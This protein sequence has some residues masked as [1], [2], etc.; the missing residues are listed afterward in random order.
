MLIKSDKAKDFYKGVVNSVLKG[1]RPAPPAEYP[2]AVY[3]FLRSRW[4]AELELAMAAFDLG[5]GA[6]TAR[7]H[8]AESAGFYLDLQDRTAKST[9]PEALRT[10][11]RIATT[12][13]ADAA[14]RFAKAYLQTPEGK[15][16]EPS[17]RG[18]KTPNADDPWW[19]LANALACYYAG[20]AKGLAD[21]VAE[22][23]TV[24]PPK[25]PKGTDAWWSAMVEL[26][27]QCLTAPSPDP[28][29][30]L[31]KVGELS[32]KVLGKEAQNLFY[33][34]WFG[35]IALA[36]AAVAAERGWKIPDEDPHPSMPLALLRLP[37][38]SVPK[39]A[40][41]DLPVIEPELAAAIER[42]AKG[43]MPKPEGAAKKT[44]A[45]KTVAKK[46]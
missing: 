27:T 45:K 37:H 39:R 6:E 3:S 18:M 44:A 20:D 40:W 9:A 10:L 11:F 29:D 25:G 22:L 32:A 28:F 35:E 38:A 16:G 4:N 5:F 14:K 24:P 12:H 42:A 36:F 7:Q 21:A 31:A 15:R 23:R 34:A 43:Q 41:G 2:A 30:L 17:P 26:A 8:L 33:E 1:A 46:R 13:D 19:Y